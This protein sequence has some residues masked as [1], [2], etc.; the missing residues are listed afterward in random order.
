MRKTLKSATSRDV[1]RTNR[2]PLLAALLGIGIGVS[3]TL[4]YQRFKS[5]DAL[6]VPQPST[7]LR[8]EVVPDEL[9][10]IVPPIANAP[11]SNSQTTAQIALSQGNTFY[12]Q[13]NWS[14]AGLQY[15]EAIAGGLDNA[16]VRTDLGNC[17]RF[18]EQP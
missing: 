1:T 15:E 10:N 7:Q 2:K 11:I 5:S 13:R 16:D 17:Y 18:L 9:K 12:D 4:T 8:D 3:G 14:Q 6:P